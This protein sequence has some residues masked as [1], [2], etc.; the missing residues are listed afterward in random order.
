MARSSYEPCKLMCARTCF[1]VFSFCLVLAKPCSAQFEQKVVLEGSITRADDSSHFWVDRRECFATSQTR[2]L[3]SN[4]ETTDNP[5]LLRRAIQVDA[6]VRVT[7]T[8]D[9]IVIEANS[10]Q[11][12]PDLDRKLSGIAAIEK[13]YSTAPELVFQADGYRIRAASDAEVSY[14]GI[15]KNFQDVVPNTW[16]QFTGKRDKDGV[17]IASQLHFLSPNISNLPASPTNVEKWTYPPGNIVN[18]DGTVGTLEGKFSFKESEGWHRLSGDQ[19]LQERVRRIGS[20]V[21]PE[22]QR[23]LPDDNPAKIAFRFYVTEESWIHADMR[24]QI[25]IVLL[26]RPLVERL[27]SDDELA[28]V[29]A[30]DIAFDIQLQKTKLFPNGAWTNV[31]EAAAMIAL[32]VQGAATL[33]GGAVAEGVIAHKVEVRLEEERAR[34]ALTMMEEHGYEPWAAPEAW[35]LLQ[36]KKIPKDITQEGYP[37]ISVYQFEILIQ[38]Y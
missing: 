9:G 18:E 21:V 31:G 28:A 25:G 32:A 11:F 12:L 33:L 15:L 7:G 2:Y 20:R 13:I 37:H 16:V 17:V 26:S 34:M 24:G 29:L 35:R 27:K 14:K 19:A 8:A 38:Q 30:D 3:P 6:H 10:V 36:F 5:Y 23:V 1:I 4:P 22:Y